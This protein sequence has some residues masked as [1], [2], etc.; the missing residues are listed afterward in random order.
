MTVP[1]ALDVDGPVTAEIFVVCRVE[2]EARLTGPCGPAPWVV[3]AA[4]SGHPMALVERMVREQLVDV[5]LVHSTSWRYDHGQLVLSFL[6]VVPPTAVE[7][8]PW[9]PVTRAGLAR[10]DA[11]SAPSD[12]PWPAVLEH[13]LR[14]LAWLVQD[15]PHVAAALDPSWRAILSGYVPAP[16]Q[17]IEGPP[18][19]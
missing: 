17:H 15:D 9:L 18:H 12:V 2:D 13:A 11:T 4:D 7:G 5:T 10:G 8:E 3:E 16:F 1:P 6:A 19:A 14:H